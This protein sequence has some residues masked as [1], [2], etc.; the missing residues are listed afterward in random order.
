[1][2]RYWISVW[3]AIGAMLLAPGREQ[4]QVLYGSIVG[5]VEDQSGG[6]VPNATVTMTSKETGLSRETKTDAAGRYSLLNVLAGGYDVKVSAGGFRTLTHSNITVTINT[7]TRVDLK[8]EV[9]TV[10]EQVT[11]AAAAAVLQTDKSD[12]RTE[13]NSREMA[14]LPL[15]NYRNFQSLI[16]LAPGV[17][18]AALQHLGDAIERP[19]ASNVNGTA[20]NNNRTRVDGATN[21]FIWLPTD[22]LYVPQWNP[23]TQ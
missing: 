9:G 6:V 20:F 11:V 3:I 17:T 12:V 10:S 18:P 23:S 13:L 19:M 16:N 15:A 22:I 8:L 2:K 5:T 7:V 1:M 14:S 4:A 21:V